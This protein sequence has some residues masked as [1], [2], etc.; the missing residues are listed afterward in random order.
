MRDTRAVEKV[1][2]IEAW[3]RRG[4]Q[5]LCIAHPS[6]GDVRVWRCGHRGTRGRQGHEVSRRLS[7]LR[8]SALTRAFLDRGLLLRPLGSTVVYALP[9]YVITEQE[10]DWMTAHRSPTSSIA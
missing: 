8:R 2:R 7:R 5:P 1:Q 3:L 10:T 6:V 9:P 4:L